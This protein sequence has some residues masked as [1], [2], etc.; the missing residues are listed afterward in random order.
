MNTE[1]TITINAPAS[2]VWA[3]F[4]DVPR[5]PSWTPSVTSVEPLDGAAIDVGHRFKIK[6]PKLLA[7]VWEVTDVD[8]PRSWTWIARSPGATTSAT[9][10][11]SPRGA[12]GCVVTQTIEHGGGLGIVVGFLTRRITRRY[13]SQEGN[14]LKTATEKVDAVGAQP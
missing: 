11:V 10:E 4:T 3:V 12:S 5:W 8:A 7:L 6:Q 9:H 2:R 14:G 13:L 1:A